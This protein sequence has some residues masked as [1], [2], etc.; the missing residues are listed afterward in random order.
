MSVFMRKTT[1]VVLSCVFIISC[2]ISLCADSK[3]C[4][5][6]GVEK[7]IAVGDIHGD[8]DNFVKVLKRAGIVDDR[9]KWIAGRT[10]FVQTGDIMDRGDCARDALDLLRRLEDEAD[11]AGGKVHFLLGNHEEMNITGIVFRQPGYVSPKQFVSFLPPSFR[12]KQEKE[13]IKEFENSHQVGTNSDPS[14]LDAYFE[15]EWRKLMKDSSIRRLY[16]NTFND[17]YGRWIA[18]HNVVIKINDI[19]FC[20]GGISERFS[21]WPLKNINDTYREELNIYRLSIKRSIQPRIRLTILYEPD[22]PTWNRDIALKDE[23][24]YRHV[25][26]QILD[27]LDA[28]YMIIAH[29]PIGSPV[30]P[31]NHEDERKLRSRFNQRIWMIDTGISDYYYGVMSFLRIESGKFFMHSWR[32]EELDEEISMEPSTLVEEEET[33]E[34]IESFLL[35]AEIVNI[36]KEAVP[37][38]TAAWKIDLDD[39]KSLRRAFFKPIDDRRPSLLPESYK[40]ELAAYALDKLF[41]FNRIP[42]T[43]ERE[44]EGFKGSLQ[45]RMENCMGLDEQQRKGISPPDPQL[46]AN[47]LDETNVFENLV[48]SERKELDDILIEKDSWNIY[49]VDFSEAFSPAPALIPGQEITRCSKTLFKSLQELSDILIEAR[50]RPY[51]NQEEISALLQR[52]SLIIK[53]IQELI[54]KKG[55]EAVLF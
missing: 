54:A 38:R 27:N 41:G 14:I 18:E 33:R 53:K 8:Y 25:V 9:L 7:I 42:P 47:A 45:I 19:I 2:F 15:K 51:L 11:K 21:T 13:F 50:L 3:Q 30:I 55:T 46:F 1:K 34:D 4:I 44:I 6:T 10:H 23:K 16:I 28:K 22:S 39:G 29:T 43:V 31:E 35:K 48:Y 40:Y 26:D 17:N 12:A 20:H 24:A 49:R 5:W 36:K 52:K 32:E 37:G